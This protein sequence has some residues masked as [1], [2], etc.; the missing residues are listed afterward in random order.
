MCSGEFLLVH[1]SINV[2][3]VAPPDKAGYT[4]PLK[5]SHGVQD[6]R[7]LAFAAL[8]LPETTLLHLEL[9]SAGLPIDSEMVS[10][11]F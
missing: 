7:K 11:G 4:L 2:T 9:E 3:L 1:H 8:N 5:L 6:L 10:R